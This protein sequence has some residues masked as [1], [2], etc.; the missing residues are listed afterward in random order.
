MSRGWCDTRTCAARTQPAPRPLT[1]ANSSPTPLPPSQI[2][3]VGS[4]SFS[5][6][7]RAGCEVY[8][9]LNGLLKKKYGLDG[10]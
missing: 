7:M 5:E 6:A 2:M 10:A 8:H 3:P 1:A 4:P 9:V